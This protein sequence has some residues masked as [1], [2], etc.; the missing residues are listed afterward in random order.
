MPKPHVSL[1]P[2]TAIQLIAVSP[3]SVRSS[4]R[5]WGWLRP[6]PNQEH[7]RLLHDLRPMQSTELTKVDQATKSNSDENSAFLKWP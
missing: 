5:A 1:P 3:Q 4:F 2:Q 6:Q 7:L